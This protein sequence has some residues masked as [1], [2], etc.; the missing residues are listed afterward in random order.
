MHHRIGIVAQGIGTASP[1]RTREVAGSL[2]NSAEGDRH[3]RRRL[4]H[5]RQT[6]GDEHDRVAG[7]RHLLIET[8]LPVAKVATKRRLR[9]DAETDLI[10]DKNDRAGERPYDFS[11]PARLDRD[12][13][14]RESE[15]GEPERQTIND[16]RPLLARLARE[17]VD[18]IALLFDRRP[19]FAALGAMTSNSRRHFIIS[20]PGGGD[21]QA[22]WFGGLS[23][24]TSVAALSRSGAAERQQATVSKRGRSG[25][26]HCL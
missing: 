21:Q 11:E 2:S 19:A 26:I 3:A 23:E 18:K 5:E 10:R 1:P 13:A 24:Q 17:R 4:Q 8:A 14:L 7:A 20:R 15:I 22:G 12:V 9:H 25:P 6:G 16:D